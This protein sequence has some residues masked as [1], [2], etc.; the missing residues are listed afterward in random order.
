LFESLYYGNSWWSLTRQALNLIID[1]TYA[2]INVLYF[3]YLNVPDEHFFQTL[4][5]NKTRAMLAL[6]R[7]FNGRFVFVDYENPERKRFRGM[8]F[9]TV[10]GFRNA[11]QTGWLFARKYVPAHTPEIADAIVAGRFFAE[12]L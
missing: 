4:L 11:G 7:R 1:D 12:I 9:L 3:K 2:D 5:G 8:D 6:G 10:E